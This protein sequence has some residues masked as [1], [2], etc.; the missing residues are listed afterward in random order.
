[1]PT[2]SATLFVPL[3]ARSRFRLSPTAA[4]Q[5][6]VRTPRVSLSQLGVAA[7]MQAFIRNKEPNA[8]KV[9]HG[10]P[11]APLLPRIKDSAVVEPMRAVSA[12]ISTRP[13]PR[14]AELADGFV[15]IERRTR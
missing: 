14:L 4:S 6:G 1:M 10:R 3:N 13:L 5:L 9:A 2:A 11:T 15:D 12:A 7:A 8:L